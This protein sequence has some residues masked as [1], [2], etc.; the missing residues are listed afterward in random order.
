VGF[1]A[2]YWTSL[3]Q[4]GLSHLVM[5]SSDINCFAFFSPANVG[6]FVSDSYTILLVLGVSLYFF[7][8]TFQITS[9]HDSNVRSIV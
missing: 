7:L 9:V 2:D 4:D 1:I 6:F 8:Q 3:Y 5:V